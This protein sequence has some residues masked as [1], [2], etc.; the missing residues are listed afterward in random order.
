MKTWIGL[1]LAALLGVAWAGGAWAAGKGVTPAWPAVTANTIYTKDKP[2]ATPKLEDLPLKESVTQYGITWT[3]DKPARVGQFVN[4]DYYVVGPVTVKALDP[5]P[6]YGSEIP[7]SELDHM[8]KGRSENQRIRNGFML[9]P[10]AADKVAYDSGVRNYFVP[11]LIQKLPVALKPGDS[12]VSTISMPLGLTLNAPLKNAYARG[13]EDASPTRM[14]AV[15]TCVSE[16]QPPDAFRPGM[17]DRQAKIYLARNLKRELLPTLAATKSMPKVE[18]YVGYTQKPWIGT[19]LFTFAQPMENQPAYGR[20]MSRV[21]GIA[22]LLLCTDL[23]PEQKEPL[24]VNFVQA[25]IDLGSMIR[26][27]HPGWEAFG[28]F[29]SGRKLPIVFAGLLLGDEQLA[30]INKSF[31]KASFG[32]DEMTAYGD[33]WTGAKVVFTGHR[34]IDERTGIGRTGPGPD[35][36]KPP[37]AWAKGDKTC[38]SYRRCCTSFTWIGQ[39]LVLHLLKAEKAWNHPAFFDYCDRWMFEDETA[40]L[41]ALAEVGIKEADWAQEGQTWDPCVNEMWAKYR[42][43]PEMPATDGWKKPHDD[44]YLRNAL[45]EAKK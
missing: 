35:E 26:S 1:V 7:A 12:L 9:N 24:L 17:Y 43:G 15:L 2:P 23:K 31:P 38:E 10:P 22:G 14:A 37:A 42:A 3:F 41:K 34:G 27:G 40:A 36:Q 45:G 32:E 16:P 44:S 6:L 8:D 18:Q 21:V 13:E 25:G 33:C 20:E 19:C 30:N 4:T 28:G 11:G 39:A 29:G 5:K